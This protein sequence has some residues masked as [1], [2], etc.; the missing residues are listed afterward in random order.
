[1]GLVPNQI[2]RIGNH[3]I[4]S[5]NDNCLGNA[6]GIALKLRR[7]WR[8]VSSLRT[9]PIDQTCFIGARLSRTNDP[10]VRDDVLNGSGLQKV[11]R[12]IRLSGR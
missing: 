5:L 10:Q 9:L 11:L 7:S 2:T 12:S 4:Q 1:M 6:A 8:L 3:C